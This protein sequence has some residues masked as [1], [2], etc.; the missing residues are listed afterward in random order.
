MPAP[1]HLTAIL[2]ALGDGGSV[3]MAERVATLY[4]GTPEQLA[5]NTVGSV[6]SDASV[7][8]GDALLAAAAGGGVVVTDVAPTLDAPDAAVEVTPEHA[9]A[10]AEFAAAVAADFTPSGLDE[11]APP[12]DPDAD[13]DP[14]D[15][16]DWEALDNTGAVVTPEQQASGVAEFLESEKAGD[17]IKAVP[18]PASNAVIRDWC[19]TN[20]VDVAVK[21]AV[22]KAARTAYDAAHT[23]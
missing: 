21:G 8:V 12:A 22:S 14:E 20:G 6:G 2:T 7:L 15:D 5:G 3:D 11:F 18:A 17:P 10:H 1:A 19:L 16:L 4:G 9:A 23:A 13:T